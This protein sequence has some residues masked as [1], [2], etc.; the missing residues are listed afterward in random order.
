MDFPT[1]KGG[2]NIRVD[3]EATYT[4][5]S[6]EIMRDWV[7]TV[8]V[9]VTEMLYTTM[10][11]DF[12]I[13]ISVETGVACEGQGYP[14]NPVQPQFVHRQKCGHQAYHDGGRLR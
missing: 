12:R 10:E 14:P 7:T 11:A 9:R 2:H 8:E 1:Q 6:G 3:A 5:V 13:E 4:E